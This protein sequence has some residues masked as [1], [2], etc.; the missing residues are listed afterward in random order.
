MEIIALFVLGCFGGF[1]FGMVGIGGNVLYIPI[2]SYFLTQIGFHD[3]ELSRAIIAN[4]LFVLVFTGTAVSWQ[5]F[6]V[7]NFF[8]KEILLTASTGVTAA[9]LIS[10]LI[11]SGNW[12]DKKTFD[13]VFT[14]LLFFTLLRL[15]TSKKK[16]ETNENS[17]HIKE[18]VENLLPLMLSASLTVFSN[19]SQK[20]YPFLLVGT[21]A[22]TLTAFSGLGGSIIMIP[23]FT[24]FVGLTMKKAH[25]I[26]VG[27]VP[28]L[29]LTIST[30]Y[31][32]GKPSVFPLPLTQFGYLNLGMAAPVIVGSMLT[33]PFG[34]RAAHKVKPYTQ[35]MVFATIVG[36]VLLK[37]IIT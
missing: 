2:F 9:F 6:K 1:L 15:F 27:V 24:E 33:S 12:Y 13:V 19:F 14:G 23:L 4:A 35:K 25:S 34:V 22:G 8:L 36:I 31:F 18:N 37:M 28:L 17:I 11:K 30:F 32:F 16:E 10:Y 26:S 7:G 20:K 21:I 29:A 5:Q 3:E